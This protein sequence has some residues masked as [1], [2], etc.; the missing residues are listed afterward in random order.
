MFA[1]S[2]TVGTLGGRAK[3]DLNY[4]AGIH[5]HKQDL[6]SPDGGS[7]NLFPHSKNAGMNFLKHVFGY[8]S[9][10]SLCT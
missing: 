2:N 10:L 5:L 8:D 1:D 6:F 4:R 3:P 7:W 9:R